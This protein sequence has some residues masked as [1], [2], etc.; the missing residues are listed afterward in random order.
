[1]VKHPIPIRGREIRQQHQPIALAEP[2]ADAEAYAGRCGMLTELGRPGEALADCDRAIAAARQQGVKLMVGHTRRFDAG[3]AE[4]KRLIEAGAIGRP[5][6]VRA[7]SG[8]TN[9]PPP[10][11]EYTSRIWPIR[12]LRTSSQPK[13]QWSL[14]RCWVP[15]WKTRP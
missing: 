1:M 15:Y 9:P 13:R 6:V 12:P 11:Q 10:M 14:E 8:D 3:H 2:P 4:A 7:I 5:L